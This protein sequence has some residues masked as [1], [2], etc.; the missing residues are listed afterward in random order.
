MLLSELNVP[1]QILSSFEGGTERRFINFKV[2]G[3]ANPFQVL[4]TQS[5]RVASNLKIFRDGRNP[6]STASASSAI[7]LSP[8]RFSFSERI[9]R[10]W[11]VPLL[12]TFASS[13]MSSSPAGTRAPLLCQVGP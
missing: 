2:E 6:P 9:S 5:T 13:V 4:F 8:M 7:P 11:S 3:C 1:K 12:M 10:S